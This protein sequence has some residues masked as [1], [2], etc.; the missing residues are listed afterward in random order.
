MKKLAALLAVTL[1]CNLFAGFSANAETTAI[2]YSNNLNSMAAATYT[3][4]MPENFVLV[5]DATTKYTILDSEHGMSFG[6]RGSNKMR[7]DFGQTIVG[8]ANFS[9]DVLIDKELVSGKNWY[10]WDNTPGWSSEALMI[11]QGKKLTGGWGDYGKTEI[12]VNEWHR[13]D[14]EIDGTETSATMTYYVDGNV[15]NADKPQ[16]ISRGIS[17]LGFMHA[18]NDA[19]WVYMDNIRVELPSGSSNMTA[20]LVNSGKQVA[21]KATNN[22]AIRFSDTLDQTAFSDGEVTVTETEIATGNTRTLAEAT[23]ELD[24]T[25]TKLEI[26]YGEDLKN[27]CKY[28]I[29]IPTEVKGLFGET[30]STET[31]EFTTYADDDLF[32]YVNNMDNEKAAEWTA[33]R[34]EGFVNP[35]ANEKDQHNEVFFA[36][37]DDEHGMSFGSSGSSRY[38]FNFP[39]TIDGTASM[40][41]DVYLAGSM[42]EYWYVFAGPYTHNVFDNL[43]AGVLGTKFKFDWNDK[44]DMEVGKWYRVDLLFEASNG[45]T[46]VDCYFDGTKVASKT[47]NRTVDCVTFVNQARGNAETD[48]IYIDNVRAEMPAGGN[49]IT[50]EFI[51][52]SSAYA[53]T[54]GESKIRFSDTIAKTSFVNGSKIEVTETDLATNETRELEKA[55]ASFD[56]TKTVLTVKYGEDLKDNCKYTIKVPEDLTGISGEKLKA[57]SKFE[58]TTKASLEFYDNFE[59]YSDWER[60]TAYTSSNDFD[61]TDG[62]YGTGKAL[63]KTNNSLHYTLP[64]QINKGKLVFS[65]DYMKEANQERETKV[66]FYLNNWTWD[67]AIN[68]TN[69]GKIKI[70]THEQEK[71][72]VPGTWY[73]YDIVWDCDT[74][75]MT[76]YQNGEVV[77]THACYP[78]NTLKFASNGDAENLAGYKLDN[79]HVRF[80]GENKVT[81]T[82]TG[83]ISA[84]TKIGKISFKDAV[85]PDSIS[86]MIIGDDTPVSVTV[87]NATPYGA[88]IYFDDDLEKDV[89]YYMTVSGVESYSGEELDNTDFTFTTNDVFNVKS[90][91]VLNGD[92]KVTSVSDWNKDTEYKVKVNIERT[93]TTATKINVVVA[94]YSATGMVQV[95]TVELDVNGTGDYEKSIGK[96]DM[97]G[98]T[99]IKCF[100]IDSMT[101][102]SPLMATP[103][104]IE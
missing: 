52:D 14:I 78:I 12:G 65:F 89:E 9:F 73:H 64:E 69:D 26:N 61:R 38:Q 41:F 8:K 76:L 72:F 34:P 19:G 104:C 18:A 16:R 56:N 44:A 58:V 90:V 7:Y 98:A 87:K 50:G 1:S 3:Q 99:K 24:A 93:K 27:G 53:V 91:A 47:Y 80:F 2:H 11:I 36:K 95:Q 35:L 75:V 67:D 55:T 15:M 74:S 86:V 88:D 23:A 51:T 57:D 45:S 101:N 20:E 102:L 62:A 29:T 97:T 94:G 33:R 82:L 70:D 49:D 59:N 22:S 96:L 5:S 25:A 42:S 48:R 63:K 68:F 21:A 83:S 77:G 28:T 13:V 43:T 71:T 4:T 54:I 66:G 40:S 60:M 6:T 79:F 17:S 39:K 30:C 84:D 32:H 31:V 37:I 10:I 103:S 100:V 81:T 85:D 46:K 92:A